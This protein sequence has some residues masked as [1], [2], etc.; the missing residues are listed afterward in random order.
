MSDS[1]EGLS[2]LAAFDIRCGAGAKLVTSLHS[3][4]RVF[5]FGRL[6]GGCPRSG[7]GTT[8]L[9]RTAEATC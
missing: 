6:L 1:L 5:P 3:A 7:G 4:S 9:R 2:Q 8:Q